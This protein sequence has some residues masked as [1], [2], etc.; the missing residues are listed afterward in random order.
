MPLPHAGVMDAEPAPVRAVAVY[1]ASSAGVPASFLALAEEA[2][3]GIAER[4]WTLV[5]GGGSMG[6][7]GRCADAALEAGGAVT[8][9]ITTALGDLEVAHRGLTRLEVVATMHERK[10]RMTAEADAFLILPGGFGTLDE[11]FEAITWKQLGLHHKP[12]VVVNAGGF[13]DPLVEFLRTA[14]DLGVIRRRHLG[15][16]T[17]VPGLAEAMAELEHPAPWTGSDER[18]W[19]LDPPPA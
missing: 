19:E 4:G 1:C 6:M 18:W 7:M 10:Q 5:Y 13:F 11:T 15:L 14:A 16:L 17:V 2:G 8:G 9:V 12:I 3:R